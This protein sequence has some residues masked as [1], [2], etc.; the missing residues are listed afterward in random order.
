MNLVYKRGK[1]MHRLTLCPVRPEKTMKDSLQRRTTVV[2]MVDC[3]YS[4]GLDMLTAQTAE[5]DPLKI[6]V[7][8]FIRQGLPDTQHKFL[9]PARR[10][11]RLR[12]E[13]VIQHGIIVK[14]HKAVIPASLQQKAF[15][16]QQNWVG[17]V[18]G[19]A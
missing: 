18:S 16:A 17:C 11:I 15:D 12:D 10:F 19:P 2:M 1:D 3:I 5:D 9:L 4:S 14:G 6:L 8:F 7:Y 13:L